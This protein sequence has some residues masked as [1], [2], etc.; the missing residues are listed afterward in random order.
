MMKKLFTILVLLLI[1]L[2]TMGTDTTLTWDFTSLPEADN[3]LISSDVDNNTNWTYN[4]N[5]KRYERTTAPTGAPLTAGGEELA[6]TLGLNFSSSALNDD[7]R[8]Y[9]YSQTYTSQGSKC[10]LILNTATATLTIPGL[11]Q[12]NTVNI[13]FRSNSSVERGISASNA[14]L[15]S[16]S[17][18]SASSSTNVTATYNVTADGDVTIT[19]TAGIRIYSISVTTN[20]V[21][22]KATKTGYSTYSNTNPLNLDAVTGGHAYY[23]SAASG[24]TVTMTVATGNVQAGEGL[25]IEGTAGQ[26][27]TIGVASSGTAITGNLLKGQ[28]TAGTVAASASGVNHYVFGYTSATD[29]GFYNLTSDTTVPAGKAYLELATALGAG[30]KANV[31]FG[32]ETTGITNVVGEN[33]KDNVVYN[34]S[35]MRVTKLTKGIYIKNGHKFIVK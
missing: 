9:V 4:K 27:F 11:K 17:Q 8:I 20:H 35:G 5:N 26:R 3:T 24:N 1:T 7:Y 13:T 10:Y 15:T 21:I 22:G 19:P 18:T 23:A 33:I 25:F 32:D 6:Y 31:M 14:T 30:A 28:V 12:N 16:G 34:L 2:T 29:Y